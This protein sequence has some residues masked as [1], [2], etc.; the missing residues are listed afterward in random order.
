M[1]F[2]FYPDVKEGM[3]VL[4][5]TTPDA[6]R[7]NWRLGKVVALKNKSCDIA[8]FTPN[9]MEYRHDCFHVNDPRCGEGR[10]WAES[11]RGVF[12]IAPCELEK[13]EMRRTLDRVLS[14]FAAFKN[15]A[16]AAIEPSQNG[17]LIRKYAAHEQRIIRLEEKLQNRK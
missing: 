4:H 7:L 3:E 5:A 10:Q 11:G 17:E 2:D 1:S 13:V 14:E 12:Q 16:K 8:I 9:G 6:T 15:A